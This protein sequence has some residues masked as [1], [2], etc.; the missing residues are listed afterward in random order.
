M[1]T[2]QL[3]K[4]KMRTD[5]LNRELLIYKEYAEQKEERE[6][7][8]AEVQARQAALP[9]KEHEKYA[10]W[11]AEKQ[12]A[13]TNEILPLLSGKVE[14]CHAELAETMAIIE[15]AKSDEMEAIR[16]TD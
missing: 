10:T 3:S 16:Q 12:L 5:A 2:E 7:R 6:A 14:I 1:D 13:Q 15:N 8:L 4:L 11:D 9:K